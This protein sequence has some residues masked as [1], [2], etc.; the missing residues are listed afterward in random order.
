LTAF[1]LGPRLSV[2]NLAEWFREASWYLVVGFTVGVLLCGTL[3]VRDNRGNGR[4]AAAAGFAALLAGTILAAEVAFA[5][6]GKSPAASGC[7]SAVYDHLSTLPTD[8]IIAGDPADLNCVPVAA[9]RPVLI[10]RKLYQ[11]WDTDYFE[12]IRARM[13]SMVRAYYGPS[14]AALAGLRTQYGADY[15][16][17]R[18]VPNIRPLRRMAPFTDEARRLR[19][20][21]PVPAA[22]R[23]PE[24]CRTWGDEKF[25]IYSLACVAGE[26]EL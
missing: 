22:L 5:G 3:W 21:V 16:L 2:S 25:E 9:R 6:G 24:A 15:L 23:L 19:R 14:T 26:P 7:R 17:V 20:S 18:L 13:F 1:P 10:S 8:A 4:Q 11:P 12:M